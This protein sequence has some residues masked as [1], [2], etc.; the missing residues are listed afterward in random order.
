MLQ[1]T[2]KLADLPPSSSLSMLN[3]LQHFTDRLGIPKDV[4]SSL[5]IAQLLKN[6]AIVQPDFSAIQTSPGPLDPQLQGPDCAEAWQIARA[7]AAKIQRHMVTYIHLTGPLTI[8]GEAGSGCALR[9]PTCPDFFGQILPQ[10]SGF[11]PA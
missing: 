1:K 4:D 10:M 9:D 2:Y 5:D 11:F 8:G 6:V 3:V 7:M